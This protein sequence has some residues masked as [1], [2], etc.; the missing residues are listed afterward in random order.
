MRLKKIQEKNRLEK[1][2]S[3]YDPQNQRVENILINYKLEAIVP[4][5][6]GPKVLEMGCSTGIMTKRLAEKFSDLTV[7]DGSKKYIEYTRNLVKKKGIKFVVSLFEDF[8]SNERFDDI[9]MANILEHVENPVFILKRAKKWLKTNG[10]I[11]ITVPNVRSLHRRIGQKMRLIKKLD[12][13]SENDRKIGHRRTYTKESLKK[14][15]DKAGLK[16]IYEQGIFLK[17][18]S[19][20]QLANWDKKIFDAFFEIGKELPDY[21]ST[22]YIVC[23]QK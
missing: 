23:K 12:D 20:S 4:M 3:L 17:P 16:A 6:S 10:R 22:I 18:L 8:N 13:F 7:V 14:D 2:A 9:I 1:V 19:N 11:H 21:C 15:I 5:I